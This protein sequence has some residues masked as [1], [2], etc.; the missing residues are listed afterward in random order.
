MRRL[1]IL[2]VCVA[3]VAVL[4]V[5]SGA[6]FQPTVTVRAGA[7]LPV[8]STV[9]DVATIWSAFGIDYHLQTE[10]FASSNTAISVDYLTHSLGATPGNVFPITLN[11]YIY[12]EYGY[13]RMFVALGAGAFVADV[14]GPSKTVFGLKATFGVELTEDWQFEVSYFWSD[15]Y[16]NVNDA[17]VNGPA[18]YVGY[19]F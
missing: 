6:Q 12:Q 9:R 17:R 1:A 16:D 11:Q 18:A 8:D 15:V 14:G 19:R 13:E 3:A 5:Q 4:S 10:F 7:W 2:G